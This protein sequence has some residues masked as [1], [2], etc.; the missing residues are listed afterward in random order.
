MKE[1][2]FYV[3]PLIAIS[4]FIFSGCASSTVQDVYNKGYIEKKSP[5]RL[6]KDET[7]KNGTKYISGWA[8]VKGK[9]AINNAYKEKSFQQLKNNCGY[10]KNDFIEA[11]IVKHTKTSWEEVWL[12]NDPKSHR[13]DKVSGMTIF[14]QYNPANNQTSVDF[15]GVCHT[16]KGT[17]F[18]NVN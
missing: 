2:N 14:F 13:D 6:V 10:G 12:F 18:T 4:T 11:R 8:G 9:S 3:I 17:T 5:V 16:G 15:F 1:T 7:F